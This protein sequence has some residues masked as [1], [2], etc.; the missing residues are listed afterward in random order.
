MNR[1]AATILAAVCGVAAGASADVITGTVTADNHYALYSSTGGVFSYHGGNELG[2][3]GS[4]GQYNWSAAESYQFDAGDF[5]YIAAWSDD[6]VAQGVLAQFHSDGLGDLLSGDNPW[7]VA[8]TAVHRG[9]GAAH[10]D[11]TEITDEVLEADRLNSWEK[12]FVGGANGA[13]PWGTIAG[14]VGSAQWMWRNNTDQVN[15]LLGDPGQTNM[16]IF[17]ASIPAPASFAFLG[18]GGVLAARRARRP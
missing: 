14:I 7:Q 16:V 3:A 11:A 15:P 6:R 1:T 13:A 8:Y 9:D 4:S 17:R 12:P 2:A 5:L 18:M 10:P